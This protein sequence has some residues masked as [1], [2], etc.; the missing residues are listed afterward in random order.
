M[1]ASEKEE[2]NRQVR[3][4]HQAGEQD[5]VWEKDIKQIIF[6]WHVSLSAII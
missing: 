4:G 2:C 3:I 5:F 6:L 1:S